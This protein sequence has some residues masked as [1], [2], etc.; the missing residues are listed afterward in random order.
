MLEIV[1][2]NKDIQIDIKSKHE[3][4]VKISNNNTGKNL[5]FSIN[6][7]NESGSYLHVYT[8]PGLNLNDAVTSSISDRAYSMHEDEYLD[9]SDGGILMTGERLAISGGIDA[10]NNHFKILSK[11]ED[12]DG[13]IIPNNRSLSLFNVD[14]QD[15]DTAITNRNAGYL[16]LKNV[17]FVN[18]YI[19]ALY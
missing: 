19:S 2:S 1:S 13:I 11:E 14:I 7:D 3:E 12:T 4:L 8:Q 17:K 16:Y 5:L 10:S 18:N 9:N 15:F 6:Y